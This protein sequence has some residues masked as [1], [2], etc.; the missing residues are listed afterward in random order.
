MERARGRGT[1][2]THPA[3]LSQGPRPPQDQGPSL[4]DQGGRAGQSCLGYSE[5]PSLG[6]HMASVLYVVVVVSPGPRP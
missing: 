5:L 2:G 3:G 1:L 6:V 4:D